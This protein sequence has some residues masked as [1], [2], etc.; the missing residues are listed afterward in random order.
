MIILI[1][2]VILCAAF[3]VMVFIMSRKPI[4][5][6]YN[7]PPKIQE[8]VKSLEEYKDSIPTKKN[9]IAVKFI[10]CVLF[11][12]VLGLIL[13]FINGYMTFLMAF[14]YGFLLWTI[15]NLWDV[16]VLDIIWFCHDPHF[17]FKGTEDMVKDYHDYWFHIKG[18]FIGEVLALVVCALSGVVVHFI[19]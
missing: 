9:K 11:V 7:Y 18:F 14:G 4:K 15:V 6:L 3:T 16:I 1:E 2:S 8:R 19:F 12:L 10:A 5:T 13:R 17:V